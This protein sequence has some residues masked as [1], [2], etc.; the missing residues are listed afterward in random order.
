MKVKLFEEQHEIDLE[1]NINQFLKDF[2]G[3]LLNMYLSSSSFKFEEEQIYS[4]CVM[5]LYE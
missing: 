2:N 1:E 5:I 4:F 3:K